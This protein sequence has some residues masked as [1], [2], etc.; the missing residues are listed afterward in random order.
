MTPLTPEKM[1]QVLR[2]LENYHSEEGD[3][4]NF[5]Y[6]DGKMIPQVIKQG[7]LL[8]RNVTLLKPS[9]DKE[10]TVQK[11]VNFLYENETL[12]KRTDE[13]LN[14]LLDIQN[15]FS[16]EFED[17]EKDRVNEQFEKLIHAVLE[18]NPTQINEP[19]TQRNLSQ[20]VEE[21]TSSVVME[22]LPIG[23]SD[24]D[25]K[26]SGN[27]IRPFEKGETIH[28]LN[29]TYEASLQK[30]NAGR[31]GEVRCGVHALKNALV[32][33]GIL[34]S[35]SI[36]HKWF[37]RK[38]VFE[39][40]LNFTYDTHP[41]IDRNNY[42][43]ADISI[44]VLQ[45]TIEQLKNSDP[46][47]L[48]SN[49]LREFR[50]VCIQCP[51]M[52]SS[53]NTMEGTLSTAGNLAIDS[54]LNLYQ[55]TSQPGPLIHAFMIGDASSGS[56]HWATLILKKEPGTP[57]QWYGCNSWFNGPE[58]LNR[59]TSV[60]ENSMDKDNLGSV[61]ENMYGYALAP[62]IEKYEGY[63]NP[64]RTLKIDPDGKKFNI[65][66]YD[67]ENIPKIYN[68]MKKVGWL[69]KFT[70]QENP[71][72]EKFVKSLRNLTQLISKCEDST[73][74]PAT[75]EQKAKMG[76]FVQELDLLLDQR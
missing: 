73:N 65:P 38:D 35:P 53:F 24:F 14:R 40:I 57:N 33:A 67:I 36:D 43:S 74:C 39:E 62:E 50:E 2:D 6:V 45:D 25:E 47:S 66:S 21:Q 59:M 58:D 4:I 61:L 11:I 19:M 12:L 60:L 37:H 76:E 48:K 23:V 64:D 71:G 55:V 18:E 7:S 3:K 29:Q 52:M 1:D 5:K 51:N 16:G 54:M 30:A 34:V 56:E 15:I 49:I 63:F 41:E 10:E 8:H 72:I 26:V 44:A 27:L 70:M 31:L 69:N 9:V 22:K 42:E 13:N 75:V 46:A 68:F 28:V 17:V 32:G 20:R